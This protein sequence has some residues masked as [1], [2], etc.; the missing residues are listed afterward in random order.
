MRLNDRVAAE[1]RAELARRQMTQQDLAA[2]VGM[3]Q[4]SVSERL[5]GKTMFT[6][7]DIERFATALEV[8]PA[9]F[10][11]ATPNRPR[12]PS[13][14]TDRYPTRR[15]T[16]RNQLATTIVHLNTTPAVRVAA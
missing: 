8:H 12:P 4:A 2:I 3:S 15:H 13:P 6:L 14:S 10:L 7:D 5:R 16:T 11:D 1:V 9:V